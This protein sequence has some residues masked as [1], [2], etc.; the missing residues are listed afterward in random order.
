MVVASLENLIKRT[1]RLSLHDK[2]TQRVLADITV[3]IEIRIFEKGLDSSNNLI[4]IY[5]KGYQKTRKREGYP[6]SKKVILQAQGDMRA[7]WVFLVLPS[8]NYGS[9]FNRRGEYGKS[10]LVEHIYDKKIFSL[11]KNEDKEIEINLEKELD[12]FYSKL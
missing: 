2:V 8:G 5:S 1:R 4:G 6:V 10:L 12:R 3:Q 9:G 7:D 11:S